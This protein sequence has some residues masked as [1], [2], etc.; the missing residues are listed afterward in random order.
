M[1]SLK[2]NEIDRERELEIHELASALALACRFLCRRLRVYPAAKSLQLTACN[3][4]LLPDSCLCD[5]SVTVALAVVVVVVVVVVMSQ[6]VN[7]LVA[8]LVFADQ[9]RRTVQLI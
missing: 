7:Q 9:A 2:S 5:D 8:P 1:I 3:W 6:L 4:W